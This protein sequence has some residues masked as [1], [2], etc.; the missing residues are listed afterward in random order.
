MYNTALSTKVQ[1]RNFN[2]KSPSEKI[3]NFFKK[4]Y[5]EN[6][7]ELQKKLIIKIKFVNNQEFILSQLY[8]QIVVTAPVYLSE[9]P[10]NDNLTNFFLSSLRDVTFLIIHNKCALHMLLSRAVGPRWAGRGAGLAPLP[11]VLTDQLILPQPGGADFAHHN[12]TR[13]PKFS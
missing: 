2:F 5:Y 13:T 12:T 6:L 7:S 1:E 11:Q 10:A 3:Y 9:F 4:I 8:F